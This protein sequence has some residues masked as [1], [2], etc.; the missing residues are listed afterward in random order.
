M[1]IAHKFTVELEEYFLAQPHINGKRQ[2]AYI[3]INI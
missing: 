2:R 1:I 3:E